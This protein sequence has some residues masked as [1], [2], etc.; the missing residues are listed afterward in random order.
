MKVVCAWCG[1]LIRDG[2]E[3]I[4]HGICPVCVESELRNHNSM[5]GLPPEQTPPAVPR[6]KPWLRETPEEVR[7]VY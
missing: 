4:S 5:H 3:P 7:I 1:K 6:N 2:L